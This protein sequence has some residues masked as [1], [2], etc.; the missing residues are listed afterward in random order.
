MF[1]RASVWNSYFCVYGRALRHTADTL[2]GDLQGWID[3]AKIDVD[4]RQP[5]RAIISPY[6]RRQCVCCAQVLFPFFLMS[7]F[8]S[9]ASFRLRFELMLSIE[10]DLECL[11]NMQ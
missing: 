6:A 4:Q 11:G 7:C 8:T 9:D 10:R 2:G 5:V 3:D 1:V